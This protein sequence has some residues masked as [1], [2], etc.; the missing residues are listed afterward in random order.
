MSKKI[1]NLNKDFLDAALQF[2][3]EQYSSVATALSKGEADEQ[4]VLKQ[5]REEDNPLN[6]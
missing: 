3:D 5:L 6:E 4:E 1:M 2:I